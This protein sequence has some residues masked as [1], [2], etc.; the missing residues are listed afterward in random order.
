MLTITQFDA[1]SLFDLVSLCPVNLIRGMVEGEGFVRLVQAFV[2]LEMF[3]ERGCKSGRQ[4][5]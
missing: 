2:F 4:C 1:K 3:L 5:T